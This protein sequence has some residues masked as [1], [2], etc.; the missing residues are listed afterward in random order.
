[1]QE[2]FDKIT[3]NASWLMDMEDKVTGLS[4][5]V[6]SLKADQGRLH[7]TVNNVQSKQLAGSDKKSCKQPQPVFQPESSTAGG[8]T[9]TFIN[10]TTH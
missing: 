7:I 9:D 5:E 4:A 6:L 3:G 2:V 1:M 10:A 8:R